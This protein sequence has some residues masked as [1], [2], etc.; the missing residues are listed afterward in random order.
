MI[1]NDFDI[2]T[3]NNVTIASELRFTSVGWFLQSS[4]VDVAS[5]FLSFT[6]LNEFS[7]LTAADVED[8]FECD[9]VLVFLFPFAAKGIGLLNRCTL[10]EKQNINLMR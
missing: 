5:R 1:E 2:A 3:L 10:M 8:V 7:F 9:N 4:T 6:N